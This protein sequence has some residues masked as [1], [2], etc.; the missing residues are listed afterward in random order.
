MRRTAVHGTDFVRTMSRCWI[1]EEMYG[2]KFA[3]MMAK[4]EWPFFYAKCVLY[5]ANSNSTTHA[6]HRRWVNGLVQTSFTGEADP[7]LVEF[8]TNFEKSSHKPPNFDDPLVFGEQA[9][10]CLTPLQCRIVLYDALRASSVFD[11]EYQHH[12]VADASHVAKEFGV[13]RSVLHKIS[14]LCIQEYELAERKRKLLF[15]SSRRE[16]KPCSDIGE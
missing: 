12:E 3:P 6:K 4:F 2:W 14:V 11:G 7:S 8:V 9:R 10:Q 13:Q 16:E 1:A 5:V 15:P